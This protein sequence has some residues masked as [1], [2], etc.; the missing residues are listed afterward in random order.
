MMSMDII[1]AEILES[2]PEQFNSSSKYQCFD[3]R[4]IS[5]RGNSNLCINITELITIHE[6]RIRI[7]N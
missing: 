6:A 3:A 2:N 5:W 7:L 1:I 4:I